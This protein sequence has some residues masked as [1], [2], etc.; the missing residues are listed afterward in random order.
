MNSVELTRRIAVLADDKKAVDPVALDMRELVGYTDFILIVTAANDRQAQAIHD[1][2]YVTLKKDEGRTPVRSEGARGSGWILL[3]YLDA[4]VH[5]FIPET[6]ERY[7]LEH[8]W[9]EADRLD[10][11]LPEPTPAASPQATAGS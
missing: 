6:R 5:I 11:E 7:R 2:I 9:G 8:L 10:L 1:E 3:D 4:I